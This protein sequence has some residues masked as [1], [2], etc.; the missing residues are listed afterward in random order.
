MTHGS[1]EPLPFITRHLSLLPEGAHVLDL[2]CGAGRHTN[3][4][5]AKAFKVTAVDID[6]SPLQPHDGLTIVT[7]DLEGAPWP[8]D[9]RT[10][11]AVL[12]TN[13]LHRPLFPQIRAALKPGGLLLYE[14]FAIGH[15]KYGRPNNPDFLLKAGELRHEFSE[16]FDILSFEEV[17]NGTSVK[18]RLA[19]KKLAELIT[20]LK[21]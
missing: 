20:D 2:A 7:A 14:T 5:L 9:G 6:T 21:S 15:E 4:C 18:Q 10:F 16:G 17:D 13:Y 3:V 12:V 11:D 19:T 8:L 1:Q